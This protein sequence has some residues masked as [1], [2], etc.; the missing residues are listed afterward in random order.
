[1]VLL[2]KLFPQ[3]RSFEKFF[4]LMVVFRSNTG[5][6]SVSVFGNVKVKISRELQ[7]KKQAENESRKRVEES[8]TQR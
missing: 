6:L 5:P 4:T 2:L 1:M 7:K 8:K 3:A